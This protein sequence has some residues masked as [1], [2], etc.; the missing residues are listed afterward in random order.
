MDHGGL[1]ARSWLR[2][3]HVH[4]SALAAALPRAGRL[5]VP[6]LQSLN[7]QAVTPQ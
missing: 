4:Q 1:P 5:E 2:E 6:R 7:G 3:A